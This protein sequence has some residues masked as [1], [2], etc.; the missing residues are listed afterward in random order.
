MLDAVKSLYHYN[1]WATERLFDNLKQLSEQEYS[2]SGCSGHGSIK[3]TLAHCLTSQWG[4]LSWLDGSMT[5][6]EAMSARLTDNDLASLENVGKKWNSIDSQTGKYIDSLT[7]EKARAIHEVITP[8]GQ[9]YTPLLG[10]LLLHLANHGTHHRAQII[11][12]IRR[13]GY[14]PGSYDLLHQLLGR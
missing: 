13:A 11:A 3:D 5:V 4:W 2:A 7:D 10:E 8:D 14:S 9:R 6:A 12:A 1:T